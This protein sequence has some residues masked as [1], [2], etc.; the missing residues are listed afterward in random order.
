MSGK[1]KKYPAWS[2]TSYGDPAGL[3]G[4]NCRHLKFPYIPGMS[5]KRNEPQ[6]YAENDRVYKESQRQRSLERDIKK[7]KREV[8]LLE[9]IGD[10]EGVKLAKQKVS[11]RQANMRDFIKATGRRRRPEREK[12]YTV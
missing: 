2:T 8:M 5:T 10:T 1:S 11:Q 6:D 7:A 3:L 9:E 12:I 4:V